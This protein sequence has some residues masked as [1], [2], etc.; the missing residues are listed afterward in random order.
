MKTITAKKIESTV[1][2]LCVKA[3]CVLRGDVLRRLKSAY[4][5]EDNARAKKALEQ[6]IKNA[7]IARKEKLAICQDTGLPIVF[8]EL[9]QDARIKGDLKKAII[10]GIA[11]GYKKGNFRESIISDPLKRVRSSYRGC[12]IHTDMVKG[13]RLKITVLPKG[14]GC[15]NKSQLKMFNPTASEA[16]IKKFIIQAVK[17]T[18]SDACPPYVVGIGIGGSS[19]YAGFLA[20][21]ALLKDVN[22]KRSKLEADLEKEINRL[23]IGPM[24]FGGKVTC[25]AV[26]IQSFPT[27]IAGLPVAVDISC[28]ALRSASAVL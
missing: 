9:G 16:E 26:R 23:H 6:I 24:G 5:S 22:A 15:E 13:S 21:V 25:L 2:G 7:R 4:K 20:K 8:L 28:H 27:H 19:D 11:S 1:A 10:I 17:T 12:L 18:G 3:N 14:F